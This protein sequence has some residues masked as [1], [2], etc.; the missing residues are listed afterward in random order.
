MLS[1]AGNGPGTQRHGC[2]GSRRAQVVYAHVSFRHGSPRSTAPRTASVHTAL[3]GRGAPAPSR[4]PSRGSRRCRLGP[5]APKFGADPRNAA[6][7]PHPDPSRSGRSRRGFGR[8][9][10]RRRPRRTRPEPRTWA[11]KGQQDGVG[12]TA[13]ARPAV[14]DRQ[15]R[16]LGPRRARGR[17]RL[18]WPRRG[19]CPRHRPRR[20][21][22]APARGA[23]RGLGG[24]RAAAHDRPRRRLPPAHCATSS[25]A[26]RSFGTAAA[27]ARGMPVR[28][29]SSAPASPRRSD[30]GEAGA[31]AG[32]LAAAGVTVVSGL[33]RGIDTPSDSPATRTDPRPPRQAAPPH[34]QDQGAIPWPRSP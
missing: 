13:D 25:T 31:P 8:G 17:L 7:P 23:T 24:R 26:R 12:V 22:R 32:A 14:G 3:R 9:S 6:R 1:L 34:P 2:R 30:D 27:S 15:A 21:R 29:P 11:A 28:W 10:A 4:G 16:R 18:G 19:L 5:K 33:A 20:R